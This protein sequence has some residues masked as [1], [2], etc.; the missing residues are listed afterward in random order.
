MTKRI[1]SD[2]LGVLN[3]SLGLTGAGSQITELADGVVDQVIEV[4]QLARRGRTLADVQGIFT[5]TLR[6]THTDAESIGNAINPYEVG[7]ALAVAPYPSPVPAQ[8]DLWL[9]GASVRIASGTA[10]GMADA[11]LSLTVGTFS[12]GFGRT[13][14]GALVLVSN[15]IRLA[16]WDATVSDGTAFGTLGGG[17]GAHQRIGLRLPRGGGGSVLT[18]KSVSTVTVEVDCQLIIGMF[19]IA[20]GQDVVV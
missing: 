17:Q 11:T 9:I 4:G 6:N 12:Q 19:P 2:A 18:F 8:F 1:D 10:G 20:L 16:W 5:P 15:Q 7:G 3:R 14:A 13:D